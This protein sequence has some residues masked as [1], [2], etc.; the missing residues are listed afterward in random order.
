MRRILGTGAN[1]GIG[2][3]IVKKLLAVVP[4]SHLYLGSRD[5]ERGKRAVNFTWQS[6][7]YLNGYASQPIGRERKRYITTI[8]QDL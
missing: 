7:T 5:V 8:I 3:A 6:L 2:L 1:K 4:D